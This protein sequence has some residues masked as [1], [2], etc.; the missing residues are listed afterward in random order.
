[1]HTLLTY[2]EI[3]LT[4]RLFGIPLVLCGLRRL[5]ANSLWRPAKVE[6]IVFL[7]DAGGGNALI[8]DRGSDFA[9]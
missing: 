8:E 1:M 6:S 7:L 5:T 3:K 2:F 9:M 4:L